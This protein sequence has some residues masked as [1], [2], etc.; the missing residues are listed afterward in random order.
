MNLRRVKNFKNVITGL[1]KNTPVK[2]LRKEPDISPVKK[3]P[4]YAPD[5]RRPHEI[6]LP[7]D[8]DMDAGNSDDVEP[9]V[10]LTRAAGAPGGPG[11]MKGE[12]TK[13]DPF[14]DA[15]LLPY[16]PT[17]NTVMPFSYRGDLT[18]ATG[19]HSI[20]SMAFR[21]NSIYDIQTSTAFT[22]DP[23]PASDTP[24]ANVEKAM[25]FNYWSSLYRYW[26]V[27]GSKY[28]LKIFIAHVESEVAS[29]DQQAMEVSIWTYHNGQQQP[30][31]LTAGNQR[32]PD[33]VRR[34]H[35]H[36]HLTTMRKHT[37]LTGTSTIQGESSYYSRDTIINGAYAPGQH[38]VENEIFEDE[39]Q[40]TWHKINEVPS[41]REVVTFILQKSDQ[42]AR[43]HPLASAFVTYQFDIE[44]L[45]Q[46]KDL[47]ADF[48]YP[49]Q[50]TDIAV[51]TDYAKQE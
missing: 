39:H 34:V 35:R 14:A 18:M 7:G 47:K 2:R 1:K 43:I 42:S 49:T 3:M 5:I 16:L 44:Y 31:L 26:T 29:T 8:D 51:I 41:L 4:R 50:D 15:K 36:N 23:T 10:N 19:A 30:P 6:P 48:Q 32:V 17:Q 21:L 27:V 25:F 37:G 45:V 13:V 33:Y 12:E 20:A 28:T 40:E 9:A 24:D 22:S 46:W 38:Y 11:K